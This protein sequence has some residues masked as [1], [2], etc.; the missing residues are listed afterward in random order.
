VPVAPSAWQGEAVTTLLEQY[1]HAVDGFSARLAVV[2][3]DQWAAATPCTDWD[4]RALVA[5][6]ADEQR[7]VPYL[8]DGGRVADAGDR[9]AADPLG[10]EPVRAWHEA[11]AAARAAFAAPDA[12]DRHVFL[13]RG[14]VS[15]RDYLWEMTVDATVHTWDLA[16]AVGADERLDQELVRRIHAEVD[17]SPDAL[18]ASGLFAPP[19]PVPAGA[20]LQ[21]RLLGLFGRRA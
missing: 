21:T 15:A 7:W 14:E 13:S 11:S 19:V 2:R 18:A 17:K 3:D 10:A 20:D 1:G 8:L 12:L 9:F 4:V 6:L 16:R 5:H